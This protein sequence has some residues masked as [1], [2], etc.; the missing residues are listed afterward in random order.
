MFCVFVGCLPGITGYHRVSLNPVILC[1]PAA[2]LK[3]GRGGGPRLAAPPGPRLAI[4]KFWHCIHCLQLSIVSYNVLQ[5]LTLSTTVY[6]VLQRLTLST[7]VYNVLQR[8]TLL[9]RLALDIRL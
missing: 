4:A 2:L 6:S 3:R 8:L 7:T 9:S 5:R 1:G